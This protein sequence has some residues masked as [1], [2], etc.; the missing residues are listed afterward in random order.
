[1][2]VLTFAHC[3]SGAAI[4]YRSP[5]IVQGYA[6]SGPASRDSAPHMPRSAALAAR[7]AALALLDEQAAAIG[8]TAG[9]GTFL[10]ATEL[11]AA[12]VSAGI[13]VSAW[14][15]GY[16]KGVEDLFEE[17]EREETILQFT[18][19]GV[20]RWLNVV[21]VR[22]MPP[23]QPEKLLVEARQ[24]FPDGRERTRG[25]PLSEKMFAREAPLSAA[26]RGVSEELGAAILHGA[27]VHVDERSLVQWLETRE[28]DSYPSLVSHYNLHEYDA[29]V[30][31][32]PAHRFSTIEFGHQ[33]LGKWQLAHEWEWTS[34]ARRSAAC[35]FRDLATVWVSPPMTVSCFPPAVTSQGA[36]G[37]HRCR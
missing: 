14:G 30:E 31:G 16:A 27:R 4:R 22:I 32:L 20:R 15:M 9:A 21:K 5:T 19:I 25:Q 1:M 13:Y 10:N 18:S 37:R 8:S 11:K 6:M 24:I 17:L 34:S 35:H 7:S 12:L 2:M 23:D 26:R 29:T 36:V 28:S 33:Q 3:A